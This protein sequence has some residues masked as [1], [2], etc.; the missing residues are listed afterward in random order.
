MQLWYISLCQPC[1]FL[2][3]WRANEQIAIFS[4]AST[5]WPLDLLNKQHVAHMDAV[6]KLHCS[7]THHLRVRVFPDSALSAASD[8]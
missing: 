8:S 2:E 4:T 6:Q 5:F 1:K 7:K 3:E